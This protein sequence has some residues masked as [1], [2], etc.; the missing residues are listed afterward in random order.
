M[1]A[2]ELD[3]EVQKQLNVK[4]TSEICILCNSRIDDYGYCACGAGG[5]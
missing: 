2:E 1:S 3:E 4:Y 5:G